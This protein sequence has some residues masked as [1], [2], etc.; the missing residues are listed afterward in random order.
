MAMVSPMRFATGGVV[1]D[2]SSMDKSLKASGG[3]TVNHQFQTNLN[4]EGE[5]ASGI[6]P[7]TLRR[8]DDGIN[9]KIQGYVEEQL[10]PGGLLQSAR[11]GA[12]R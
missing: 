12:K 6:D 10:R 1:R 8:L 2:L 11:S 5:G 4:V 7:D 9:L 3:S